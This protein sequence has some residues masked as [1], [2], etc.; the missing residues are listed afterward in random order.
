MECVCLCVFTDVCV[1]HRL[2]I[3]NIWNHIF[4]NNSNTSFYQSTGT[5]L[6]FAAVQ[7]TLKSTPLLFKVILNQ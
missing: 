5:I 2:C 7:M 3:R 4:A 6:L 1:N